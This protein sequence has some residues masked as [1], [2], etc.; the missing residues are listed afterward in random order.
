M[1]PKAL[2]KI[3]TG[4]IISWGYVD[5]S[6]DVKVGEIEQ[7]EVEERPLPDERRFC[8]YNSETKKIER[9]ANSEIAD[10]EKVEKETKDKETLIQNEMRQLAIDSLTAKGLL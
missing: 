5:F 4:E 3:A 2:V 8:R 6:K 7:V 9:K 10:I 1:K